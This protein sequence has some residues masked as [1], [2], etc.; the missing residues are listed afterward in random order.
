MIR[1]KFCAFSGQ[2]RPIAHTVNSVRPTWMSTNGT[3]KSSA[4][5][6]NA[7]GIALDISR[8]SSMRTSSIVR[9]GTLS[10]SS[11]LVTHVVSIHS[12]HTAQPRIRVCRSVVRSG[13]AMRL[14]D[15]CVTAKTNTR[16][17]NSST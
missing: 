13:C 7:S 14:C 5:P 9:T 15:S 2:C 3:A 8:P 17:K 1:T 10:G 16:S 6:S 12:H 11:Q 4:L